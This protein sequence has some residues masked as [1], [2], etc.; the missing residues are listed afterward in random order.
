[1]YYVQR[2]YRERQSRKKV[3][4]TIYGQAKEFIMAYMYIDHYEFST[5]DDITKDQLI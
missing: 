3:V 2:E 5:V 4:R 1:M